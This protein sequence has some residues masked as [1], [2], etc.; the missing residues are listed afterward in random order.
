MTSSLLMS[1]CLI[2]I[3]KECALST[4]M[5]ISGR[6]PE[7]IAGMILLSSLDA[8]DRH[9]TVSLFLEQE[10]IPRFLPSSAYTVSCNATDA[11]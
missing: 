4:W 2:M 7:S 10:T 6:Q 11:V 9:T 3:A 8:L 5:S 1:L